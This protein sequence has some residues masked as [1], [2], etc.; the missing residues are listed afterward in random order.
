MKH[1]TPRGA[2]ADLLEPPKPSR[3]RRYDCSHWGLGSGN[4]QPSLDGLP[5]TP[6]L[7]KAGWLFIFTLIAGAAWLLS[8]FLGWLL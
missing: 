5:E 6:F 8:S 2:L 1:K 4:T 7:E 3:W